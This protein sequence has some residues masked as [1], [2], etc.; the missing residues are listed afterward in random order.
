M[1][2]AS[3]AAAAKPEMR[4]LKQEGSRTSQD[5]RAPTAKTAL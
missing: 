4:D 2:L 5:Y 3:A 1:K